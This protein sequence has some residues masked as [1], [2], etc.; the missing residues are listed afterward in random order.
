M[1]ADEVPGSHGHTR[2][3]TYTPKPLRT[4]S[5]LFLTHFL[6]SNLCPHPILVT[7]VGEP[8]QLQQLQQQQHYDTLLGDTV[9]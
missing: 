8:Q 6:K 4:K 3:R 7:Y 9:W 2:R 5:V 1:G